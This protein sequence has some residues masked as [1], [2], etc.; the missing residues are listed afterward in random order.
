MVKYESTERHPFI[1]LLI[2]LLLMIAGAF[3]FVL[4]AFV[5]GSIIYGLPAMLTASAGTAS[6]IEVFKILQIFVSTGMFIVPA[7]F[8][9]RLESNNWVDY[10]KIR[11]F[12]VSFLLLVVLIMFSLAPMLELSSELNKGMKLPDFLKGLEQWM[13]SK[14]LEMAEMTKQLLQMNSIGVLLFNLFML[15]VIP[16]L[17]EEFIFRGCIQKLLGKWVANKHVAIWLTAIIFSAMHVQFYGFLPRMLLGALFGYLLLWS[18]TIWIPVLAHFVNNSVAVITAY[19]YQQKGI[20][21]DK[22][23]QPDPVPFFVYIISFFAC[24]ALLWFFYTTGLKYEANKIE[25]TDGSGLD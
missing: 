14:E 22:L 24:C 20:S 10:L 7:L 1:S 9:A 16:A 23:D 15:A 3:V 4:L 25:Q 13:L 21:L 19:T 12:P 11:S 6:S 18:R 5:I 17:G 8:F 2:L